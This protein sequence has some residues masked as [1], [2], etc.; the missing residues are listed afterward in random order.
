MQITSACRPF[1][2]RLPL[3]QIAVEFIGSQLS[4][5]QDKVK[6]VAYASSTKTSFAAL[7]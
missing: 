6:A 4:G 5:R 3:L 1:F 7:D 2:A